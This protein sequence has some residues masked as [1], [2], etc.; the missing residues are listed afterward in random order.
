MCD[1]WALNYLKAYDQ[2][3]IQTYDL[4]PNQT[5]LR[6]VCDTQAIYGP[7]NPIGSVPKIPGSW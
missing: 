1:L 6:I 3:S 7:L 5:K 4:K 2:D